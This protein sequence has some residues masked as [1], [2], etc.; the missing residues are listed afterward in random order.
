ME[1]AKKSVEDVKLKLDEWKK[2]A[3]EK[4]NLRI[5]NISSEKN[6]VVDPNT[7]SKLQKI[8]SFIKKL[9]KLSE[10]TS[11]ICTDITQLN[12]SKFITEIAD[13]IVDAKLR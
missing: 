3:T 1:D 10:E 13:A 8:Q 5:A 9:N 11:S 4:K 7:A 12:L 2:Q 6:K